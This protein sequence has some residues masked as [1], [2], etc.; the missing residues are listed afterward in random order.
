LWDLGFIPRARGPLNLQPCRCRKAIHAREKVV[1]N[2]K[3]TISAILPGYTRSLQV[4][5]H[6]PYLIK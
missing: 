4:R 5:A 3:H 2:Q 1:K 6:D